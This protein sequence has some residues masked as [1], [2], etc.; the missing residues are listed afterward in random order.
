M[1]WW[2]GSIQLWNRSVL[3]FMLLLYFNFFLASTRPST[4]EFLCAHLLD[5]EQMRFSHPKNHHQ[6]LTALFSTCWAPVCFKNFS[7]PFP[8]SCQAHSWPLLPSP[9]CVH[10]VASSQKIEILVKIYWFFCQSDSAPSPG[11]RELR[12]GPQH[13]Q[14]VARSV[15]GIP[16]EICLFGR[17]KRCP[18]L[19][20][21]TSKY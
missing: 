6:V 12:C 7:V 20:V 10:A 3:F 14:S 1:T 4:F 19:K 16:K 18:P 9:P 17:M 15:P 5:G 2:F 21:I 13:P 8:P 11:L